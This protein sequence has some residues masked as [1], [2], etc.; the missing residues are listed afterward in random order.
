[1]IELLQV[2]DWAESRAEINAAKIAAVGISFGGINSAIAMGIDKRLKA[3]V[4]IVTGGNGPK[5]GW[6][7]RT[8]DYNKGRKQTRAGYQKTLN[9]Y[10]QYLAEVEEKGFERVTPP[11][12]IFLCDPMTFAHHLRQRP[13]LMI[14]ALWDRAIPKEATLDFWKAAG[15]P[16]ISWLPATHPTIWLWY[17]LIRGKIIRFLKSAFNIR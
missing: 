8:S 7:T 1:M 14:N 9:S 5:I 10:M 13:V 12:Q 2:I 16:P 3:G 11:K 15:K 17:P 6:E 4:F